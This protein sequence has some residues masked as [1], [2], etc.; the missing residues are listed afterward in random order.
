EKKAELAAKD[1]ANT[2]R[3]LTR[4]TVKR[5]GYSEVKAKDV[6]TDKLK[7]ATV[8][9]TNNEEV[10]EVDRLLMNE[11]DRLDGVVVDVGGFLGLG[12]RPVA[13]DVEELQI[14]RKDD[15]DE[16]VVIVNATKSALEDKPKYQ[17]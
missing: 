17:G 13:F 15:G 7:G 5:D 14:L 10:G 11:D 16:V 2:G 3:K 12:E 1:P 9:G 8:Y 4:P 6:A